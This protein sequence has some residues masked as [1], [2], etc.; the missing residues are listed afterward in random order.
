MFRC[1]FSS[2]LRLCLGFGT[3]MGVITR[4][5]AGRRHLWRVMRGHYRQIHPIQ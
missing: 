3:L 1:S 4:T 5:D 2:F